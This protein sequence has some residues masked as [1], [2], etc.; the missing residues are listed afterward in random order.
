MTTI[1]HTMRLM[2]E[3]EEFLTLLIKQQITEGDL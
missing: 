3:R 2:K 1:E